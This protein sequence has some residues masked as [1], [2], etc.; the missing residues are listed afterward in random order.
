MIVFIGYYGK[1]NSKHKYD[2][3]NLIVSSTANICA[4]FPTH[5]NIKSL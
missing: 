3:P 5:V 4:Y 1:K 2:V